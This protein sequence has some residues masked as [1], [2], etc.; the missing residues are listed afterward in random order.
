M[1]GVGVFERYPWEYSVG[2]SEFIDLICPF[3]IHGDSNLIACEEFRKSQVNELTVL[4]DVHNL[5]F[6]VFI[7]GLFECKKAKLAAMVIESR[8][9]SAQREY[10]SNETV[11]SKN[12]R[13]IEIYMI[14]I[15]HTWFD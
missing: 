7:D 5:R 6:S 12:P 3:A 11:R 1:S 9:G 2:L 13:A 8:Y 4:I 15:A 10:Q 14:S